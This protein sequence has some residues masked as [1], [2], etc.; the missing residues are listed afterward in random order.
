MFWF[1][2]VVDD[3]IYADLYKRAMVLQL[4]VFNV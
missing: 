1:S 3:D 4:G 2:Y